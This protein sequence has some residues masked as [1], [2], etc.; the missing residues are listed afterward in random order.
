[1]ELLRK[2]KVKEVYDFGDEL[3]FRFT[4]NIS[5]FDKIIPSQIPNKGKILC[6]TS[7]FWFE[8]TDG[9]G[10]KN[11]YLQCN[12]AEMKVKKFRIVERGS[13]NE[14]DFLIPLEFIVRYYVAGSLY[15]RLKKGLISPDDIGFHRMP[16]YG[17]PLSDPMFEITTK[18]EDYDRL[19]TTKEAMEIGGIDRHELLEIKEIILKID[20]M[21]ENEVKRRNLIH[22]DGKKEFALN[23]DRVPV[24][25]D[26]LGTMDEDRWWDLKE[27][28]NGNIVQLSKEFVRDYYRS[29]GYYDLLM[30]A[31]KRGAQ[32][33]K[34]PPLPADMI[35]RV[36]VLYEM[37]YERITGLQVSNLL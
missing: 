18:F 31:R 37:M 26:T 11:H 34:I 25:V 7:A 5:V 30:E 6:H 24:V 8:K 10:I 29:I 32:E 35:E 17:E 33:P 16:E 28:E 20:K 15:S 21:M 4:D 22:V 12:N 1:M 23:S 13:K 9:I 19:V 3:L 27:Y 14:R 36:K 2:G